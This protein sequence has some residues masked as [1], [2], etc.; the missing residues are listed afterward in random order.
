M[1]WSDEFE[2]DDSICL[3][4]QTNSVDPSK[5]HHQS[6]PVNGGQGWHNEEQHYTD[7]LDNS[8]IGDGT[9]KSKPSKKLILIPKQDLYKIT[10]LHA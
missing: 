8:Y 5:W 6:Y 10:L 4:D 7:R 1:V 3:S 2:N 9:L